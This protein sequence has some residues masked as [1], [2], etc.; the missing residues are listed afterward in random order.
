MGYGFGYTNSLQR[1]KLRDWK[2]TSPYKYTVYICMYKSYSQMSKH[3]LFTQ[4]DMGWNFSLVAVG[5]R[6]GS[7]SKAVATFNHVGRYLIFLGVI[8][9][10]V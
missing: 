3:F 6:L 8:T 4:W 9:G 1:R 10:G 7:F 2:V 5:G